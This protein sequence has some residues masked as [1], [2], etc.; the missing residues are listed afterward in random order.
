MTGVV[1]APGWSMRD[2][3]D[4]RVLRAS[5]YLWSGYLWS[6]FAVMP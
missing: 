2:L 5:L 6:G 3:R 4:P 1:E